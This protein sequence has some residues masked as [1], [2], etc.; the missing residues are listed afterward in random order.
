MGRIWKRF[1][2]SLFS[3]LFHVLPVLLF[4]ILLVLLGM[5]L[6]QG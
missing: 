5:F 1:I 3:M 2:P 6:G 4:W